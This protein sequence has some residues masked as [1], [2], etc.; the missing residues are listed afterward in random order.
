MSLKT[1]L[2]NTADDI[3]HSAL[4]TLLMRARATRDPDALA[5]EHG[6]TDVAAVVAERRLVA[7]RLARRDRADSGGQVPVSVTVPAP[8][9][10]DV[11]DYALY[12]R[13]GA[14]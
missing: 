9:R 6:F 7:Q 13:K 4:L 12:L 11:A 3:R 5:R 1:M 2:N 10:A 14:A 8:A